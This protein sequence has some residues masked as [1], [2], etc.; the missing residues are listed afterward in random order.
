MSAAVIAR[1]SQQF[2]IRSC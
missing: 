2:K 1:L